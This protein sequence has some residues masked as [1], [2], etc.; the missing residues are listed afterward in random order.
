M[1]AREAKTRGTLGNIAVPAG[2]SANNEPLLHRLLR[3]KHVFPRFT[4]RSNVVESIERLA[5]TE[6]EAN[7]IMFHNKQVN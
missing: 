4:Q 1:R 3:Q 2:P 6:T 7:Q 5:E